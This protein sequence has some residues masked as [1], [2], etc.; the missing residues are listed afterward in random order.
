MSNQTSSFY[1]LS[2]PRF[3]RP[4]TPVQGT[5]A[6]DPRR[7]VITLHSIAKQKPRCKGFFKKIQSVENL[8][9]RLSI[10]LRTGF[11]GSGLYCEA[12]PGGQRRK[13]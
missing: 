8:F 9:N 1:F 13:V 10:R 12:V 3:I 6:A 7:C 4:A 2:F 5:R 11:S